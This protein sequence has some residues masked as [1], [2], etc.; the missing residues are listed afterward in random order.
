MNSDGVGAGGTWV[1]VTRYKQ[2]FDRLARAA[3]QSASCSA[4]SALFI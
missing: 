4:A 2:L 1:P 3:N